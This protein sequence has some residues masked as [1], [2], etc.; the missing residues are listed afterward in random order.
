M[1]Q[2]LR[3]RDT[4]NHRSS[5]RRANLSRSQAA[6]ISDENVREIAFFSRVISVVC[7]F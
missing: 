4:K 5:D 7:K 2:N 1:W 3:E 6:K